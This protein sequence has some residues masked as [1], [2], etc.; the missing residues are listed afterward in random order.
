MCLFSV[1]GH[2]NGAFVLYIAMPCVNTT[3]IETSLQM[4]RIEQGCLRATGSRIPQEY[5]RTF[6]GYSD[7]LV[8][9]I[10]CTPNTAS[11]LYTTTSS[12]S[13]SPDTSAFSW[14][15]FAMSWAR[16][17]SSVSETALGW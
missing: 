17:C 3:Y 12:S 4:H 6:D 9:Y 7:E 15:A 8:L 11:I 5:N 2:Q 1:C 14:P 10:Y 16:S 13:S